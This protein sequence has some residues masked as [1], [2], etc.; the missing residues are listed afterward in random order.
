MFRH[1]LLF[2]LYFRSFVLRY[3]T[4][5]T[6]ITRNRDTLYDRIDGVLDGS[7]QTS[8]AFYRLLHQIMSCL[9]NNLAAGIP[10]LASPSRRE[11][12]A[13]VEPR[14]R[15]RLGIEHNFVQRQ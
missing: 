7:I 2:G 13:H 8:L 1:L 3:L 14:Q 5:Y 10:G 12:A 9:A 6:E 4:M 15:M 11:Q